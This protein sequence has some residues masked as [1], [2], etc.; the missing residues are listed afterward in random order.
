MENNPI[1]QP[2]PKP[3][4]NLG[5][6]VGINL[7]ILLGLGA[8]MLVP[9]IGSSDQYAGMGYGIGMML[10]TPA[11]AVVNVVIGIV[12]FAKKENR[13]GQAFLLAALT[14]AVVGASACFGG[15][16]VI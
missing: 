8:L 7:A 14:V 9:E 10:L 5:K 15:M 6:I 3:L 4:T 12:F 13:K 11:M 2:D 1:D 16:A